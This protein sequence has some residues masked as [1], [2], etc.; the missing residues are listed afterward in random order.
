[1]FEFVLFIMI[2]I[3]TLPLYGVLIWSYFYP[4]ESFLWGK[5][6]MYS[7]EPEPSEDAIIFIKIKS[8]I[9]I[10]LVTFI[11]V[12]GGFKIFN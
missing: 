9:G 1:M 6:W 3:I 11:L 12:I 2:I 7:E 5:R 4:E 10:I 8:I